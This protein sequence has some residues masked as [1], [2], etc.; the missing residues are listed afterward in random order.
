[1]YDFILIGCGGVEL[2]VLCVEVGVMLF[3]FDFI[4]LEVFVVVF[5]GVGCV[6]NVVYNVGVVELGWVVE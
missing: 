1:M 2:D 6:I 5:V 4:W 3:M